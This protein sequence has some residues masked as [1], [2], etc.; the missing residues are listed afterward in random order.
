MTGA[1][2]KAIEDSLRLLP[3]PT[4]FG[5]T[6]LVPFIRAFPNGEK[7]LQLISRTPEIYALACKFIAH[8]GRYLSYVN[9]KAEVEMIA[10]TMRNPATD[11]MGVLDP[12]V[13]MAKETVPNGPEVPLA[14]DRLVRTSVE[15]LDSLQ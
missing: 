1:G 5:A 3:T 7:R 4:P 12:V 6:N 10:A 8:G 9:D 11:P 2:M 13:E 15:K 14:V